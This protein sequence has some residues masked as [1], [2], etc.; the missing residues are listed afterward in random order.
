MILNGHLS[1]I[2]TSKIRQ[3]DAYCIDAYCNRFHE[4]I[5]LT[6]GQP[7]FPTPSPVKAKAMEA[8]NRNITYYTPNMGAPEAI[9]AVWRYCQEQLNLQY[10]KDEIVLT[11]G[12]SE[13]LA[14]TLRALLNEGDEVLVPAPVYPGYEPLVRLYGATVK[15][16]DTTAD[17]F[18]LRPETLAG[19]LT[20]R[21][22]CVIITDPNNPTGAVMRRENRDALADF[23]AGKEL[24]VIAD[25]V[26]NRIIYTDD[27]CSFGRYEQLR[28]Q[29]VIVNS[30]S[31]S[32]SMTGWRI[33]YLLACGGLVRELTKVHQYYVTSACS[34]TQYA[35]QA[36]NERQTEAEVAAMVRNYRECRDYAYGFIR[37]LGFGCD[38]PE[39]A[40]YLFASIGKFG[41]DSDSFC[42]RL[43][44]EAGV[45]IIPGSCFG[46][47]YSNYIRISYCV[48][49]EL[50]KK[51]LDKVKRFVERL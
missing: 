37:E 8:I 12:S 44:A 32:H 1:E 3:F 39:G 45:A 28:E 2:A 22:K 18:E 47:E 13:A 48:D 31:K 24:Y 35:L 21:T 50:L 34:V 26:Y 38:K 46:E 27:Y 6:L 41:M 42:R 43:V 51:A 23:L 4:V 33:G 16:V 40:F 25:E 5:K 7:L 20:P 15:P 49:L 19:Y 29:L 17:G 36:V 9:E 14:V 11:V 10:G 30:F